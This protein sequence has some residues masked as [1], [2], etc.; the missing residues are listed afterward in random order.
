M[1]CTTSPLRET[2]P[3]NTCCAASRRP[4]WGRSP[5]LPG[6]ADIGL[7]THP[8]AGLYVFPCIG[9]FV[10]GDTV[11]GILAHALADGERPTMLVDIGTNGE[12]VLAAG[13]RI[14]ASS[15]AAGPAF[16]GAHVE[17]AYVLL[18]VLREGDVPVVRSVVSEIGRRD[19]HGGA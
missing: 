14:Q 12:I 3:C 10:G 9:G 1:R 19:R 6:A 7:E 11:A 18:D 15:T 16:E 2:R 17:L 13:G 4:P 5:S 8:R